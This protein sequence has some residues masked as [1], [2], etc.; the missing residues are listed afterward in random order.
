MERTGVDRRPGTAVPV[1]K[2]KQ[3]ARFA[4]LRKSGPPR[5]SLLAS[6]SVALAALIAAA[7]LYGCD[8]YFFDGYYSTTAWKVFRQIVSAFGL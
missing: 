8:G 1:Q 7:V 3:A 4:H 6:S 5:E 2:P